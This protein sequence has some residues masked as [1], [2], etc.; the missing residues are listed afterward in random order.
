MMMMVGMRK[1][2]TNLASKSS[3]R[4]RPRS[5]PAGLTPGMWGFRECNYPYGPSA[6][7]R[8]FK[9]LITTLAGSEPQKSGVRTQSGTATRRFSKSVKYVLKVSPRTDMSTCK[10]KEEKNYSNRS[11]QLPH[12]S[13]LADISWLPMFTCSQVYLECKEESRL[14][15]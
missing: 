5:L 2:T 12:S 1:M 6:K 11:E 8:L 9:G 3:Q 14:T 7:H 4:Q 10:R 15:D 13:L